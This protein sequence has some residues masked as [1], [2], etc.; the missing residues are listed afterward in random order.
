VAGRAVDGS[1]DRVSRGEEAAQTQALKGAE[2]TARVISGRPWL[3][4]LLPCSLPELSLQQGPVYQS[5]LRKA[6]LKF[7][8][9]YFIIHHENI[10]LPS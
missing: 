2:Q 9:K 1:R 5:D 6:Q 10:C 4:S 8:T 7:L 3:F